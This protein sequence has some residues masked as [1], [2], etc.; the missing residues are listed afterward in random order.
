MIPVTR[1]Q[2]AVR[3]VFAGALTA[4]LVLSVYFGILWLV[5]PH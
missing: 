4:A 2:V 5:G 3:I 1:V